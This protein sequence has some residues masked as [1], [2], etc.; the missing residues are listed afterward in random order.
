MAKP[1][2]IET[3]EQALEVIETLEKEATESADIIADLRAKLSASNKVAEAKQ[4]IVKLKNRKFKINCASF[5]FNGVE[6]Q[7]S[8]IKN[9]SEILA[10][11]VEIEAGF[12]EEVE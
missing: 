12:L 6:H 9:D 1:K 3:L 4:N 11:L 10:E 5:H 2:K 8:E 7:A